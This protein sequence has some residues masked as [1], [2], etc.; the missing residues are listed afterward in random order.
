MY[1]RERLASASHNG[2]C[3]SVTYVLGDRGQRRLAMNFN[4][5]PREMHICLAAESGSCDKIPRS[6]RKFSIDLANKFVVREL[7]DENKRN[8]V[9]ASRMKRNERVSRIRK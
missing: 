7:N 2:Q 1:I 3:F 5:R 9:S 4:E 6:D 8:L